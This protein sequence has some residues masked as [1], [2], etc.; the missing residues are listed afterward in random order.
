MN[1]PRAPPVFAQPFLF[2]GHFFLFPLLLQWRRFAPECH[3]DDGG[4]CVLLRVVR[5]RCRAAVD[6]AALRCCAICCRR[7]RRTD[8]SRASSRTTKRAARI[9][10]EWMGVSGGWWRHKRCG[11]CPAS[12]CAALRCPLLASGRPP[13][14]ATLS[15]R[16]AR[17]LT[18][19][20][21][22]LSCSSV[23]SAHALTLAYSKP[24]GLRTH[25]HSRHSDRALTTAVRSDRHDSAAPSSRIESNGSCRR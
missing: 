12:R 11:R 17:A 20:A 4:V 23:A 14:S 3:P 10:V 19:A 2:P 22:S 9:G 24:N 5:A 13:V 25:L 7:R 8:S 1:Y 6:V 21:H 18:I 15:R 16:S